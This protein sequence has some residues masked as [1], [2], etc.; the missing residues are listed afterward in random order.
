MNFSRKHWVIFLVTPISLL[1]DQLTKTYVH[2]H[3]HLFDEHKIIPDFFNIVYVQNR[4]LAFGLFQNKIG[5][6]ST[7]IFLIIT[8]VALGIIIHLFFK[9]DRKAVLLPMALS[10]VLAG[11]L[12]NLIDRLHWGFVVDF[13]QLYYRSNYWPTFNVADMSITAGI[14]LLV[15][16][17]FRPQPEAKPEPAAAAP[18]NKGAPG[19]V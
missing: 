8:L 1:A 12:G 18:E 16:D 7:L 2:G 3:L 13:L 17:S 6:Y 15:I 4:G 5:P 9:T 10:L 11:A 19:A 14:I